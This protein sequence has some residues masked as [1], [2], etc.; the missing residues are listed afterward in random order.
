MKS[1]EVNGK[2]KV[3]DKKERRGARRI[4]EEEREKGENRGK[5]RRGE[6]RKQWYI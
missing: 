6:G 4:E 2:R 3:G 1:K 5:G